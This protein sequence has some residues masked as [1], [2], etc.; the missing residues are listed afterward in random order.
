MVGDYYKIILEIFQFFFGILGGI[1]DN[2]LFFW[3]NVN[4]GVFVEGIYY[5]I[6]VF[7]LWKSE[8]EYC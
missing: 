6:S 4:V 5:Y 2:F 1:I 3:N 8:L 7:C